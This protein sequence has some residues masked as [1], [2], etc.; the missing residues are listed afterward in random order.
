M[1]DR[2]WFS[3]LAD[4]LNYTLLTLVAA[5]CVLPFIYILAASFTA[6]E[7][8]LRKGFVLFPTQFSLEGYRYILSTETIMYSL[9]ISIFITVTGTLLN[10][11]FTALMAYPLAQRD[12]MGANCLCV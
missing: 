4:V 3:R 8:L 7:E 10:L 9:G 12:L 5:V 11:L 6:P 1:A 2:G